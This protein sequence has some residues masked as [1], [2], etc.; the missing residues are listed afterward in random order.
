MAQQTT[1]FAPAADAAAA[2]EGATIITA[3]A[4][5][6]ATIITN[7]RLCACATAAAINTGNL[8]PVRRRA[9]L[10]APLKP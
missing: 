8:Y 4:I 6:G 10:L 3:A 5:E 9:C 2:I 1:L 7:V